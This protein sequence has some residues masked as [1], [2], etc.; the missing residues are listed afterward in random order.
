MKRTTDHYSYDDPAQYMGSS[1]PCADTTCA[2]VTSAF[3][4]RSSP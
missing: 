2:W 3:Q 4:A 1:V